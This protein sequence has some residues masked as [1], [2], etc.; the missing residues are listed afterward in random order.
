[1][2]YRWMQYIKSNKFTTEIRFCTYSNKFTSLKIWSSVRETFV[3][4]PGILSR[5]LS[6]IPVSMNVSIISPKTIIMTGNAVP[7]AAAHIV[8]IIIINLSFQS[9]KRNCKTKKIQDFFFSRALSMERKVC[10]CVDIKFLL[11]GFWTFWGLTT[12]RR[13]TR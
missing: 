1:M 2:H 8:P 4:K 13:S 3:K 9:E 12:P 6:R 7:L 11:Q 10:V 5:N